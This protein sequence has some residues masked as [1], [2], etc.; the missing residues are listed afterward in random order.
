MHAQSLWPSNGRSSGTAP[1]TFQSNV[2]VIFRQAMYIHDNGCTVITPHALEHIV[3]R[4]TCMRWVC[5]ND[6]RDWRVSFSSTLSRSHTPLR[7]LVCA[8][9]LTPGIHT[10]S[11][12]PAAT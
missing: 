5:Q 12:A 1:L 2:L 9:A 10:G 4:R 3:A 11:A 6:G 7:Q 8:L